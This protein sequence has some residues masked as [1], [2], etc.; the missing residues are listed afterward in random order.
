M[1]TYQEFIT[2]DSS[3]DTLAELKKIADKFK[4]D[5][6]RVV[7]SDFIVD[8]Y[9]DIPFSKPWLHI[10]VYG[11]NPPSGRP[12]QSN[13][14]INFAIRVTDLQ[15]PVSISNDLVKHNYG[16]SN[17]EAQNI[18]SGLQKLTDWFRKITP[19]I[20]EKLKSK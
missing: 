11:K 4:A 8:C 18:N 16:F 9:A 6:S 13:V 7:G 2:E 1:K 5:L 10:E 14:W 17:I 3:T 12:Q 15:S 19:T 20:K